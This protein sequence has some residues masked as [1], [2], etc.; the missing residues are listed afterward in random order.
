LGNNN[1]FAADIYPQQLLELFQQQERQYQQLSAYNNN[2]L[3]SVGYPL[4]NANLFRNE[5]PPHVMNMASN[6]PFLPYQDQIPYMYNSMDHISMHDDNVMMLPSG[7]YENQPP[8]SMHSDEY[9]IY[10]QT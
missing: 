5:P 1:P 10:F 3:Y 8:P 4:H 7:Y 6:V 2:N 9:L